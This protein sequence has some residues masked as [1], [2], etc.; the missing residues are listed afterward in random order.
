MA[1]DNNKN[2]NSYYYYVNIYWII[3]ELHVMMMMC[4]E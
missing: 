4:V 1:Y 3:L 2:N